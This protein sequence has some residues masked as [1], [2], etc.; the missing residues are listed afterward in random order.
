MGRFN[1]LLCVGVLAV[2]LVAL[3][4]LFPIFT[5]LGRPALKSTMNLS[6]LKH[7]SRSVAIYQTDFDDRFPPDMSS[8]PAASDCLM[9]YLKNLDVTVS[10][11]PTSP[12]FLGNS[13][14]S[15][16]QDKDILEPEKT[17]EFFDSA[18]WENGTRCVSFTDSYVKKLPEVRFQKAVANRWVDKGLSQK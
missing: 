15:G 2:L 3:T 8:V 1:W 5:D 14:L 13:T 17:F 18:P 6:N 12:N 9:P 16:K 7:I 11:N 10:L 4:I